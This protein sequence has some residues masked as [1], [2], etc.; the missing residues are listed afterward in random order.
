MEPI[1][2]SLPLSHFIPQITQTHSK[3]QNSN[4]Y[5][6]SSP[7]LNSSVHLRAL[8]SLFTI[9]YSK[10]LSYYLLS[11][12]ISCDLLSRRRETLLF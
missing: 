8:L 9:S 2:S 10:L 3:A 6:R 5:R 12:S 4:S 11:L 7:P 1:S